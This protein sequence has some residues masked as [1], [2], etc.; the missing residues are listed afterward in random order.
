M[1]L[2]VTVTEWEKGE[3]SIGFMT[4]TLDR[5]IL[6]EQLDEEIHITEPGNCYIVYK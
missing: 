3:N 4:K 6:G 5:I 1:I 2:N